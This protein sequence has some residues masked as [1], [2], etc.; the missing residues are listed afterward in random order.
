M[1][2]GYSDSGGQLEQAPGP[3]SPVE[4]KPEKGRFLF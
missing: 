1:E 4:I 2:M 3:G